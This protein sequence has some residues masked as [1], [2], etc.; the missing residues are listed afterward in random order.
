MNGAGYYCMVNGNDQVL[1][2]YQFG[3]DICLVEML[4]GI[5]IIIG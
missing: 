1:Y 4:I 5:V 2:T 3:I